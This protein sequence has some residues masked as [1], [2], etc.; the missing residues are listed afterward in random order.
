MQQIIDTLLSIHLMTGQTES[1]FPKDDLIIQIGEIKDK[2]NEIYDDILELAEYI[3]DENNELEKIKNKINKINNE[4]QKKIILNFIQHI[5]ILQYKTIHYFLDYFFDDNIKM[6][7]NMIEFINS[8][9]DNMEKIHSV[10]DSIRAKKKITG[11]LGNNY[12]EIYNYLKHKEDKYL[13]KFF[14]SL[15]NL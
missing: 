7:P 8:L 9:V 6:E 10:S 2:H 13:F 5:Y 12:H 4:E 1:T 14:N 3:N 15:V 11:G